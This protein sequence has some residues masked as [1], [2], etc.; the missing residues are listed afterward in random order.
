M[1]WGA[2][3]RHP[4]R[5]FRALRA[6]FVLAYRTGDRELAEARAVAVWEGHYLR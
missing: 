5:A 4:V 2:V 6:G 3:I 1:T